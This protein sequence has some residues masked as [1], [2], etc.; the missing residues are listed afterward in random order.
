[1]Y[2]FEDI[3]IVKGDQTGHNR[4]TSIESRRSFDHSAAHFRWTFKFTLVTKDRTY[5]LLAASSDERRLWTA[6]FRRVIS[7]NLQKEE[8]KNKNEE[9]MKLFESLPD[10]MKQ[11]VN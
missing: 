8:Q 10:A 7:R 1:M 5:E 2:R 11:T 6:D 9:V 4:D 3:L